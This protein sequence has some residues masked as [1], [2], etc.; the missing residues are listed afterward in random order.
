VL[1][2]HLDVSLPCLQARV[3]S[4]RPSQFNPFYALQSVMICF[5]IIIKF[6]PLWGPQSHLSS[7]YGGVEQPGRESDH[8]HVVSKVRMSG[9]IHLLLQ[10]ALTYLFLGYPIAYWTKFFYQQMYLLLII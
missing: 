6:T 10:Y 2:V 8:S 5:N 7:G 9:A 1:F 3:T 4:P